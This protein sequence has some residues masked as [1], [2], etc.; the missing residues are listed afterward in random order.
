MATAGQQF[1]MRAGIGKPE[2]AENGAFAGATVC[3]SP[4]LA[5]AARLRGV[6]MQRHCPVCGGDARSVRLQKKALILM[7]C[8]SCGMIYA[9]PVPAPYL[10]GSYYED[11][12]RPFYLSPAKLA[13]DYS[14][15][16]FARE[17]RLFRKHCR[18]GRVLD[19][20]C[21]T[22][23]FL[24]Q[25]NQQFPGCYETIGADVSGPALDYA[26]QQGIRVIRQS[27]LDEAW[28]EREMDAVVFWAALEHVSEPRRFLERALEVLKPGGFCFVLVPNFRSLAVR[29]LKEKYRYILGQHLNYFDRRT[30]EKLVP[31]GFQRVAYASTHFNPVVILRDWRGREEPTDQDRAALLQRTTAMKQ[32]PLLA[33]MRALY[34]ASEAVLSWLDLADNCALVLRKL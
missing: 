7:R 19:V 5:G 8:G 1:Q 28:T 11:A 25:L 32:N 4:W 6:D 18:A 31:E 16:R 3:R 27:F 26:E 23:A 9:S 14:P 10:D 29:L 15:V 13:A 24:W 30:L 34:R 12:G 20:G 22:G 33:P 21:S 2:F 17:I